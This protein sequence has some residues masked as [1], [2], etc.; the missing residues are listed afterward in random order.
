MD[1]LV[2]TLEA[3]GC[4]LGRS[5]LR[6][7][8]SHR[9]PRAGRSQPRG[10]PTWAIT[11]RRSDHRGGVA[12]RD[13]SR[14]AR[15]RS[16]RSPSR[17]PHRRVPAGPARPSRSRASRER[18]AR[19]VPG[20]PRPPRS[21]PR[22]A[23]SASAPWAA[24]WRCASSALA[25]R[26]RLQPHRGQGRAARRRRHEARRSRAGSPRRRTWSS[27][28]SPITGALAAIAHGADGVIAGSGPGAT[29]V[30][31]ST[32]SPGA[33]ARARRHSSRRR[34][35]DLPRRPGA[36]AA[37]SRSSRA[38]LDHGRRRRGGAGARAPVSA[39]H[40][41][42]RHPRRP[43]G[44]A[45]TMKIATNLGLAVQMLAFSEAVLLAEKSGIS[46][47]RRRRGAAKT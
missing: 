31:M 4:G 25:T 41:P 13:A 8:L 27:A 37:S 38:S 14:T 5:R 44:L 19:R 9:C 11:C 26:G 28:W 15:S 16:P 40:R 46:R 30:E 23:S 18:A 3:A 35:R 12:A 2:K 47:A 1:N 20:K 34:G 24:A 42:H 6:H 22:S 32:V 45:V 21:R 17:T 33:C 10:R 39:R 7:A 29:W 43:R 36:P